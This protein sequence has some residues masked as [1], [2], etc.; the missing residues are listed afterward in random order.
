MGEGEAVWLG[1]GDAVAVEVLLIEPV[2]VGV[3]LEVQL[4]VCVRVKVAD[5]LRVLV[6]VEVALRSWKG[7]WGRDTV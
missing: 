6:G 1:D 4:L 2:T 5:R 7:V 3:L